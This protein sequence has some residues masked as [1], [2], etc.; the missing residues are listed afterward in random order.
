[1]HARRFDHATPSRLF[2]P[3]GANLASPERG[4][5]Q[6]RFHPFQPIEGFNQPG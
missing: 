6:K 1:M 3:V 5:V 4:I 2:T